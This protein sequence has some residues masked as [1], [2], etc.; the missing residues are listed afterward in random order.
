LNETSTPTPLPYTNVAV[1]QDDAKVVA[2]ATAVMPWGAAFQL[3][4]GQQAVNSGSLRAQGREAISATIN[5][6]AYYGK[7]D[8]LSFKK[9]GNLYCL[10]TQSLPFQWVSWPDCILTGGYTVSGS[11]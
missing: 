1:E 4:D 3:M 9:T 8:A 11:G 2:L 7:Y 5:L 10:V 6:T